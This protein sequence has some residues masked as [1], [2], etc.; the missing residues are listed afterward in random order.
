MVYKLEVHARGAVYSAHSNSLLFRVDG[1]S[2]VAI[3]ADDTGEWGLT[4]GPDQLV[5]LL[6]GG[7]V[8][9]TIPSYYPCR[10]QIHLCRAGGCK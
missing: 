8:F 9:F 3:F 7:R 2:A 5:P 1:G 6:R 10:V 4:L